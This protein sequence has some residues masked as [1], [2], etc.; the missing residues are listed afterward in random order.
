M[1][2]D[3]EFDLVLGMEWHRQHKSIMH[4]QSMIME[5]TSKGR[6]Y[7]LVPYPR[8]LGSIEGEPELGCNIISLRGALKIL[9]CEGTEAVLYFVRNVNKIA[10]ETA[11]HAEPIPT[12]KSNETQARNN[13]AKQDDT[14][15]SLLDEYVDVF[16]EK[17]PDHLPPSRGLVHEINT[18]N[19]TPINIQPYQL[20]AWALEEQTT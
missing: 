3:A 15:Q 4:W 20:A 19:N 16:K 9:K 17:L 5:I 11:P 7:Y 8:W 1:D 6:K 18:G 2:L 10:E 14:M 13:A 12:A